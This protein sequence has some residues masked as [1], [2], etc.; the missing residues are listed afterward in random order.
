MLG[1]GRE[2]AAAQPSLTPPLGTITSI[3]ELAEDQ[4]TV[5]E[6]KQNYPNPTIVATTIAF[7]LQSKGFATIKL[8]D[9]SG[10]LVSTILNDTLSAGTWSVRFDTSGL[11]SGI[12]IYQLSL[13]KQVI[14]SKHLVISD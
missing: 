8:F 9:T 1:I 5:N 7:E 13:D 14:G 12:Y 4:P 10:T 3:T 6:L 11:S 2:Q